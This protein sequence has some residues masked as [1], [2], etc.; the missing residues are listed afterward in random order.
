RTIK[1]FLDMFNLWFFHKF[2]SR[3]LH[4]LGSI[5]GGFFLVGT[6]LLIV[7]GVLRVLGKVSLSESIWPLISVFLI[8][9]GFQM[10]ISGLIMDLIIQSAPSKHYYAVKS[11]SI[12]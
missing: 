2:S 7:L 3:P 5:G 9:F 8:L 11:I 1:G 10:V 6:S 4:L 12:H